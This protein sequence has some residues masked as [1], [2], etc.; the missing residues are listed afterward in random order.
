MKY[1]LI[2]FITTLLFSTGLHGQQ[3]TDTVVDIDGNVYHTVKIG[4][5]TWMK[6]N[7]KVTHYRNG[8]A[9]PTYG[10][11]HNEKTGTCN[12]FIEDTNNINSIITEYNWY[13]FNDPRNI[14]PT[15]YHI[16]T[17][18]DWYYFLKQYCQDSMKVKDPLRDI[19]IKDTTGFYATLTGFANYKVFLKNAN[20]R[21]WWTLPRG[22]DGQTVGG[23]SGAI[24]FHK[25][26][27]LFECTPVLLTYK[28][29]LICVKD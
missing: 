8:D 9:I 1:Y 11:P 4:I 25:D 20:D 16:A 26:K 15:G 28:Y 14:A 17:L 12:S 13:A 27:L 24:V 2:L 18:E 21:F 6:E 23:I 5:Q 19:I 7:L 10:Q 29:S 22:Q 3:L